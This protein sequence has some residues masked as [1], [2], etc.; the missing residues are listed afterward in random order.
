MLTNGHQ[1]VSFI[2]FDSLR[3]LERIRGVAFALHRLIRQCVVNGNRVEAIP[4]L[5][6][7]FINSYLNHGTL[8]DEEI[9]LIPY[10]IRH[11]AL[12]RLSFVVKGVYF[13]N[14]LTWKSDLGKQMAAVAEADSFEF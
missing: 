6:E 8:T 9:K 13:K 3:Y 4:A 1:L 11:E 14:N 7:Q 12:S 2:D 10:F 5:R